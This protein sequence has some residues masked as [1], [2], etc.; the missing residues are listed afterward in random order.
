[1]TS[2][3]TT[4]P[5]KAPGKPR[6]VNAKLIGGL[7]GP[8]LFLLIVSLPELGGMGQSAQAVLAITA[9]VATW[10]IAETV[11]LAATALI[12]LILFP[13]FGVAE[14]DDVIA[15]YANDI[16]FLFL[17]GFIIA[18]ALE[19]VNLHRRIALSIINV[20]GTNPSRLVLGFMIATMFV[21]LWISNTATTMMMIPIALSI[22]SQ[23]HFKDNDEEN[24]KV[25]LL[26]KAL[27]F[28]TAYAAT[29]GGMGTLISGTPNPIFAAQALEVADVEIGFGQFMLFGI[30]A[31]I[32]S[33]LVIWLYLT[34][35]KFKV[36]H[37]PVPGAKEIIQEELQA[38][39]KMSRDEVLVLVTSASIAFLWITR[40]FLWSNLIPSLSDGMIS[41]AG[42]VALFLLPA[43]GGGRLLTWKDTAKV[44]WDVLLLFGGGL[45]IAVGFEQ[46]GLSEWFGSSLGILQGAPPVL[47]VFVGATLVLFLTEITSNT[48]TATLLIPVFGVVASAI[49]MDPMPLMLAAAL[50][51]NFAF[52]LPVATPP[53]A[54]AYGTGKISI[55]EMVTTG[56]WLNI[57]HAF[58]ITAIV[59]LWF[60]VVF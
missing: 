16:I 39:G 7:L 42:V 54:I 31:A 27:I 37:Q 12:P 38:L 15:A 60:P 45:A 23:F 40:T 34:R 53:N 44:P 22:L 13:I 35:V 21:S 58:Y 56:F 51:A 19:K 48:A 3:T 57:V 1:M 59:M 49:G 47:V 10:W 52:M 36:G 33:T 8:A 32:L 28:G 29:A 17:G 46:S 14:R 55:R 11:P 6:A 30:P 9:W 20:M 5:R 50:G 2:T 24:R 18:A 26:E 41:V 43:K 25:R 4:T